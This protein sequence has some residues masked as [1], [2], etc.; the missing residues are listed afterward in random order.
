MF[1]RQ[2]A[3][4]GM[5]AVAAVAHT[6]PSLPLASRQNIGPGPVSGDTFIHDPTVVKTPG[7]SYIAAFTADNVGLKTSTDRTRWRDAGSAFPNGAP[8]HPLHQRRQEPL[9]PRHLLPQRPVLPLLLCLELRLQPLGHL[10]RHQHDGRLGL[11][12][13]PGPRHR[14]LREQRLQRHRPEPHRR[15]R[16]QVVAFLRLLL[17]RHQDRAPRR[18][19]RQARRH[20]HDVPRRAPQQRRRR[21]GALHH[22]PRRLLLPLGLV[23]QVLRGRREHVPHHGRALRERHG[24]VC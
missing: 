11:L 6:L 21:R 22:A 17:V 10:P 18:L 20:Q 7:G 14:D 8:D 3:V 2:L 16:G 24:A 12:D 19:H 13:Q 15:R 4:T 5:L 23:R 9:G 1:L